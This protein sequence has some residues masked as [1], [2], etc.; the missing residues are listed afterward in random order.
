VPDNPPNPPGS[1]GGGGAPAQGEN[2]EP[3]A[4]GKE[5]FPGVDLDDAKDV[6]P[7]D[8]PV[9][10]RL[11][12]LDQAGV[13]LAKW[14]LVMIS[15][16]VLISIA[17]AWRSENNFFIQFND[18]TKPFIAQVNTNWVSMTNNPTK[19]ILE[20]AVKER[21]DFREYW[22]KV[23][24]M[25]LLNVLLPVLTAL[26]GYVFGSRRANTSPPAT[27]NRQS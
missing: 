10:L 2:A 12:P 25:V 18:L 15:V 19:D 13:D 16:F 14:V 21:S 17:W 26:L 22:L 4:L 1:G 24:Q 11:E 9:D 20:I 7:P 5:P 3:P 8:A 27:T 23:V 6:T